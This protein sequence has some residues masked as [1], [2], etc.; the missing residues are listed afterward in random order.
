MVIPGDRKHGARR[1]PLMVSGLLCL[2][3]LAGG[4]AWPGPRTGIC[5]PES[6]YLSGQVPF[7]LEVS[8]DDATRIASV[9]WYLDGRIVQRTSAPPYRVIIDLGPQVL[10]HRI[11]ATAFT[12]DAAEIWSGEFRTLGLS[13][14]Y[15]D[16][17]SL[18]VVPVTVLHPEGY[19]QTGLGRE[20]F[21][22][23]EDGVL[24]DLTCFASDV[25]PLS[26]ALIVDSSQSMRGKV[27]EIRKAA[28]TLIDRLAPDDT[29]TVMSFDDDLVRHCAFTGDKE[30]LDESLKAFGASGGTALYDALYGAARAFREIEGKRVIILFTDGQDEKYRRP[31]ETKRRLER[32]ISAASRANITVY[33]I[34]L[35]RYVDTDT[36]ETMA[37]TTGGAYFH[38][39]EIRDLAGAYGQIFEE[40]GSQY[41]LCYRPGAPSAAEGQIP[42]HTI[43]V[44]VQD[45]DLIVRH[46]K[47]YSPSR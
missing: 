43:H 22:V 32:A 7:S 3:A 15:R 12:E 47:G 8:D 23:Y 40:L 11:A 38:L 41:T 46:K 27:R 16:R 28:G 19:F 5:G 4:Q 34:G 20:A 17:V 30:L 42:W 1:Q 39:D 26:V 45:P 21:R 2:L 33:T 9:S 29:A 24:R 14:A 25:V 10:S 13:V 31:A 44:E 37:D 36:L 18:V 35:G 6:P